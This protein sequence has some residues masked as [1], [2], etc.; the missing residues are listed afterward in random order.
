MDIN[1]EISPSKWPLYTR[2]TR[3]YKDLNAEIMYDD[4]SLKS[5]SLKA[6]SCALWDWYLPKV[7]GKGLVIRYGGV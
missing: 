1:G 4:G 7:E 6:Q 5:G 3:N 2:P